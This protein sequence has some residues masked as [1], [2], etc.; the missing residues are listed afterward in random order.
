MEILGLMQFCSISTLSRILH[1]LRLE[2]EFHQNL[3]N[4]I[5]FWENDMISKCRKH[6]VFPWIFYIFIIVS[7]TTITFMSISHT[8]LKKKPGVTL[9]QKCWHSSILHMMIH[10]KLDLALFLGFMHWRSIS[11]LCRWKMRYCRNFFSV[12]HYSV[13][14]ELKCIPKTQFFEYYLMINS[15]LPTQPMN[16]H[17]GSG[18]L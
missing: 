11:F 18:R 7:F 16:Q 9:F 13:K 6:L 8:T 14:I 3:E 2:N 17:Y 5:C 10:L 12:F 1:H 4:P 15:T